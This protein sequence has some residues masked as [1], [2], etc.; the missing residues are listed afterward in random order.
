MK[1]NKKDKRKIKLKF[2]FD[3]SSESS[4]GDLVKPKVILKD[5]SKFSFHFLSVIVTFALSA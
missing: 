2:N 4:D 3:S 1:K 5:E